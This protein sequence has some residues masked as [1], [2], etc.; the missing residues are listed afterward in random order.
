MLENPVRFIKGVG[1]K[2]A[3]ILSKLGIEKAGDLLFHFPRRW[4]DRR[5][6]KKIGELV[7]GEK[8]TILGK[9]VDAEST[10]TPRGLVIVK[11]VIDDISGVAYLTWFNQPYMKKR[12][13]ALKGKKVVAY[14]TVKRNRWGVEIENPEWEEVE[15]GENSLHLGRI[16]PIYPLTEGISQIQM[17]KIIYNALEQFA[18]CLE[19]VIPSRIREKRGLMPI[20]QAIREIHFP[21][22]ARSLSEARRRLVYE[23]FFLLQVILALRQKEYKEEKGRSLEFDV[24]SELE[25]ILPFKLT[26]AQRRVIE[27]VARDMR[28]GHP[29]NRLIQGD[30]GSGKTIV[31][32]AAILIAVRCGYQCALMAPT[33]ILAEQHFIVLSNLLFPLGVKITLLVGGLSQKEKNLAKKLVAEGET[34]LVIGTHAL[35][36]EDV[37][38]KNLGLVIIDEQHRFGVIQR[39][40]LRQKGINPEVLV[41][42]ATP[43]PRTLALTVYGD[44]DVSVIDELP[45]GRQPVKTFWVPKS[46]RKWAYSFVREEIK[47]GRQA[48]AVCPL[49][50]ESEKL[51]AEAAEKLASDLAHLLPDV[52]IGLLHGQMR[53][54]EKEEVMNQF[55]E[56]KIDLL[57]STPVIEVG[58]DVP[59]ATVMVI[60]DADRFGLAQLHQL[61]GRVGRGEYQS[62]C[63]L[64]ATPRTEEAKRRLQVMVETNDGFRIAE[65]DLAIRGPGEFF[66][67]RQHGLPDLKLANIIKDVKILEEAREDGM[68]IIE[69]DPHLRLPEHRLLAKKIKERFGDTIEMLD[70]G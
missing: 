28:E 56:R 61:R 49:I 27:E 66:G 59:N 8:A 19:E 35:L 29:M 44:L 22:S 7:D 20:Y 43:I 2:R 53:P 60:E 32:L 14:G 40:K 68:Q 37:E 55:R 25:K 5:H 57:V 16:V 46:R 39:A 3:R 31:A 30:V 45:P 50:E 33:E 41:M 42:T 58:I 36:E 67:T 24:F 34:D 17:R 13:K 21:S 15:E 4:E 26:N 47:K 12:F 11:A 10:I 23:E 38:F 69:I 6:F 62:Y 63:I 18:P 48:Y 9:V 54:K 64:I 1:E 65:E 51:Q 52:K 70:I